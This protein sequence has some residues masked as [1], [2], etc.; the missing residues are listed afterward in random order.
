MTATSKNTVKTAKNSAVTNPTVVRSYS[1]LAN[2]T[3]K[4]EVEFI[5][6]L[7]GLLSQNKTSVRIAR[8]SI[9]AAIEKSGNAPTF[10]PSHVDSVQISAALLK[11][12]GADA[13]KVSDILKLADRARK[14]YGVDEAVQGA[15]NWAGNFEELNLEVPTIAETAAEG[16]EG[17]EK[18]EKPAKVENVEAILRDTLKRFKA[19]GDIR[20][21]KT[22]DLE[23]LHA[24]MQLLQTIAKHSK[25][26]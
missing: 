23:Q 14:A 25:A 10:R 16:A 8:A 12:K 20:N 4:S 18:A 15:T 13:A 21:L 5:Q 7:A 19:L 24:T 22:S 9:K 26:A 6:T 17:A 11:V 2:S 3:R 1:A